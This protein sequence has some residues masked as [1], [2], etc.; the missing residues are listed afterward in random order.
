MHLFTLLDAHESQSKMQM[1]DP[2][3]LKMKVNHT[4]QAK[5]YL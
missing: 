3:E 1:R 5:L 4:L 2:D